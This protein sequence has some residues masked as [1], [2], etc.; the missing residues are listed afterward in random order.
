M[1]DYLGL[2]FI[3]SLILLIIPFTAWLLG[4]ITRFKDNAPI[5]GILR[6]FFGGIL[7]I[8]DIIY[9]I[10][11]GKCKEVTICRILKQ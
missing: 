9:T 2:D 10:V 8:A 7:W 5:A 1:G 6:I 11:N 3:V 4:I